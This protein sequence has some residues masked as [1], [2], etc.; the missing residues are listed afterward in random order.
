MNATG[1]WANKKVLTFCYTP[2]AP[3]GQKA[4]QSLGWSLQALHATIIAQMLIH[5][6]DI[7]FDEKGK[8]IHNNIREEL[9]T[10]IELL[11]Y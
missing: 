3:R 7:G 9:D 8:L 4:M 10:A 2:Y 1:E 5:H 6:S 11:S